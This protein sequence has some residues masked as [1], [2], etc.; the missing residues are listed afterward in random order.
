[1]HHLAP[2]RR[3]R[4]RADMLAASVALSLTSSAFVHGDPIPARHTCEGEDVSP[5]LAWSGVPDGARSLAL[6]VD[7]PDAPSGTFVHWLA[8]GIDPAT[9]GLGEGEPAPAEGSSGFGEAR[10]RGPCPPPGDGVHRYFFRLMALDAEP[11]LDPGA[12]R[13]ELE[14]AIDGHVL[15]TAE[16]IGT[17][18]R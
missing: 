18:E 1:M 9:S 11:D 13:D 7:D 14:R 4:R 12:T 16:L 10:Y 17:Y 15:D 8:W 5:P 2:L 6:I 3:F